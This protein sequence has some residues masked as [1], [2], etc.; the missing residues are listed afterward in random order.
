MKTNFIQNVP[1]DSILDINHMHF[2]K[3][4]KPSYCNCIKITAIFQYGREVR[5]PIKSER[6]FYLSSTESH[7]RGQKECVQLFCSLR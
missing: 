1:N 2:M 3:N 6:G 5:G 4:N 7:N